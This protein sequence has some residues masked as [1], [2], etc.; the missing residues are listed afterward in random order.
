MLSEKFG[1]KAIGE[2]IKGKD[3]KA[4][5]ETILHEA[6]KLRGII[7]EKKL[8]ALEEAARKAQAITTKESALVSIPANKLIDTIFSLEKKLASKDLSPTKRKSIEDFLSAVHEDIG[9]EK[10]PIKKLISQRNAALDVSKK[11]ESV[12][13]KKEGI[14]TYIKNSLKSEKSVS[15]LKNELKD[16]PEA[17]MLIEQGQKAL[18]YEELEKNIFSK[19]TFGKREVNFLEKIATDPEYKKLIGPDGVKVIKETQKNAQKLLESAS[20]YANPSGTEVMRTNKDTF[21]LYGSAWLKFLTTL[22]PSYL[23]LLTGAKQGASFLSKT[24]TDPQFKQMYLDAA[25][26]I[27]AAESGSGMAKRQIMR[28]GLQISKQLA[29]VGALQK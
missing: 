14:Q 18:L 20:F 10:G 24:L 28:I 12:Y 2:Y 26:K 1:R 15:K 22:N 29:Q 3:P 11:L 19:D 6:G 4:F 9:A 7:S 5:T 21:L 13:D 16:I 8:S 23:I 25:K 17:E 27:A